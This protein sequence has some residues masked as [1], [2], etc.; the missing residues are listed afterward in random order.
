MS[1][2]VAV[3]IWKKAFVGQLQQ[4]M[5]TK[6]KQWSLY[7]SGNADLLDICDCTRVTEVEKPQK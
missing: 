4:D 2:V 3:N 1:A 6:A 7:V 5:E